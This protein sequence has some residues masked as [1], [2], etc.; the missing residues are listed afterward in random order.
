MIRA[1]HLSLTKLTRTQHFF[2]SSNTHTRM[3]YLLEKCVSLHLLFSGKHTYSLFINFIFM[4]GG[5][6]CLGTLKL[7]CSQ[8][9]K[10]WNSYN[11]LITCSQFR[12]NYRN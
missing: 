3:S 1:A 5:L 9:S 8:P 6:T 11:I 12:I 10:C 7:P 4:H 2:L